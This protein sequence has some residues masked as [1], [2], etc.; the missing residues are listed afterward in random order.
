MYDFLS[1][2]NSNHFAKCRR[3]EDT[4]KQP[5]TW[6]GTQVSWYETRRHTMCVHMVHTLARI[7]ER[8]FRLHAANL[9]KRVIIAGV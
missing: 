8:H 3:L 1:N 2:I 6:A 4:A 9:T 5:S 7:H